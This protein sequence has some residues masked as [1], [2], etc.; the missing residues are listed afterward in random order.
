[1][2]NTSP[3]IFIATR[4]TINEPAVEILRAAEQVASALDIAYFVAGATARDLV[5][6]SVFGLAAGRRTLDVDFGFA[7][8]DWQQF[9]DLKSAFV[10]TGKFDVSDRVAHRLYYRAGE[11]IR[12]IV[13]DVIPFGGVEEKDGTL[14]WA[15][16]KDTVMNVAGFAEALSSAIRVQID[17][18]LIVPV[19]SLP[20]LAVLKLLAWVDRRHETNKDA[21]D[22]HKLL[23]DY[24]NAGNADRIYGE[25]IYLL[26]QANYDFELAGAR[27]LGKDA[28]RLVAPDTATRILGVLHSD[29]ELDRLIA[30]MVQAEGGLD[31]QHHPDC[32]RLAQAF[33]AGFIAWARQK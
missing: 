2:T 22:L 20:G 21:A 18:D 30:Q 26:E 14:A 11:Q 6:Q 29:E 1:M 24:A 5:L 31:M 17:T 8:D 25:E 33:R 16:S 9:R 32:S 19:V 3:Q 15:P 28:A 10:A 7:V 13:V 23:R 27:L 4:N 12:S